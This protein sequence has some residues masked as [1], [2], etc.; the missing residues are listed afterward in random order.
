MLPPVLP[1]RLTI[2]TTSIFS[3]RDMPD[4]DMSVVVR[5]SA[6]EMHIIMRSS[7]SPS[8]L[9]FLYGVAKPHSS[10]ETSLEQGPQFVYREPTA[11]VHT[12]L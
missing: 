9:S 5:L 2:F 12:I 6:A 7:E 4:R 11:R 3:G 10:S 8:D 1:P